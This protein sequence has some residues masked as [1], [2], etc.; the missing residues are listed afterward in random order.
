MVLV[1][2]VVVLVLEERVVVRVRMR[3]GDRRIVDVVVMAIV[4]AVQVRVIDRRVHVA[5]A[6]PLRRVEQNAEPEQRRGRADRRGERAIA[7]RDPDRRAHEWRECEH[8]ARARGADRT[9]REQV[10]PQR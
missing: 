9:L 2:R 7:E 1:G 6:V 5:V 8:G 3:A 4:V 10:Q